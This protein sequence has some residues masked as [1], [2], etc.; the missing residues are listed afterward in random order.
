MT[1]TVPTTITTVLDAAT[2]YGVPVRPDADSIIVRLKGD[3]IVHASLAAK[4]DKPLAELVDHYIAS[5]GFTPGSVT[6]YQGRSRQNLQRIWFLPFDCDLADFYEM[7]KEEVYGLPQAEIEAMLPALVQYATEKIT[8]QGLPVTGIDY[9]GHGILCRVRLA[10]TDNDRVVEIQEAHKELV[11]RINA[12]AGCRLVDPAC[13]DAGTRIVRL[14]GSLNG[15]S[16][17]YGQP[18]RVTRPLAETGDYLRVDQLLALTREQRRQAAP[19]PLLAAH[20]R[21]LPAEQ[22]QAIV[23][24]LHPHWRLGQKHALSLAIGGMLAKAGVPERQALQIVEA[25]S[26]GDAKPWDRANSVTSSYNRVRAGMD[27]RGYFALRDYVPAEVVEFVDGV[28][29]AY[30]EA[31]APRIVVSLDRRQDAATEAETSSEQKFSRSYE[32]FIQPCPESAFYGWF[33]DYRDLMARTTAAPD[34]FHLGASLVLASAM[35][36]RRVALEYNSEAL[37]TNIFVALIGRTGTTFKDTSM[38]RA[39][40]QLPYTLPPQENIAPNFGFIRD[41]SSQQGLFKNLAETKNAVVKMSELTTM[42]RNAKR[43]GT[44][45]IIDAMIHA[46]DGGVLEN[47]SKLDPVTVRDYQMNVIAATQPGRLANEMTSEEIESGF[48]NRWIYIFGTGKEPMAI[49]EKL[50]RAEGG[51]LYSELF[52]AINRYPQGKVLELT[53]AAVELWKHWF[54][55]DQKSI[56]ND[57]D[58]DRADMRARHANLILKVALIYAISDGAPAIND[59][60]LQPAIDFIGWM[61]GEVKA[62]MRSWGASLDIQLEERIREVLAGGPLS[63]RVL[64]QKV[65]G[66]RWSARDFAATIDAMARN[67]TIVVDSAGMVALT[68]DDLLTPVGGM[69]TGVDAAT[70]VRKISNGAGN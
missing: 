70:N 69:L 20:G 51:R 18:A 33:G 27:V 44:Q 13:T 19:T 11:R 12:A 1:A 65:G 38:K 3:R 56:R 60:H 53:P 9:T 34:Q 47:N 4:Q 8:E 16:I 39:I 50:D 10:S 68:A 57:G 43:K 24:A 14:V 31:N 15:K 45:T 23:D 52:Q 58:E 67:R 29:N 41:I 46:W 17:P 35:T 2:R 32:R 55:E 37:Y 30:R 26:A 40:E 28:L 6:A 49:T 66:R 64:Q 63:R 5:G 22:A 62:V 61:W 25:L 42:L 36:N 48:A 7:P 59:G 54:Y 21:E